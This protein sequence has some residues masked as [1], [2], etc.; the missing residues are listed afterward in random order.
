MRAIKGREKLLQLGFTLSPRAGRQSRR[1]SAV[2]EADFAEDIAL[3]LDLMQKAQ[4]PQCRKHVQNDWPADQLNMKINT[5][6]GTILAVREDFRYLHS[7]I[8]S[9]GKDFR[10]RKAPGW[11]A[12]QNLQKIWRSMMPDRLKQALFGASV[13]SI[14]LNG[15]ESEAW[16]VTKTQKRLN[17]M[18]VTLTC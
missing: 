6:D 16:T 12:C 10:V 3:V 8:N 14:L 9:T 1:V 5:K 13:E 4:A 17:L 2:G 11:K 18:D 7:H 15:S